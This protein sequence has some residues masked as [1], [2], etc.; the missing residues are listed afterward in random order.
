MKSIDEIREEYIRSYG[1]AIRGG[2][3]KAGY[4]QDELAE[5]IDVTRGTV[6][7]Y[8][9]GVLDVPGSS[10]GLISEVCRFPFERYVNRIGQEMMFDKIEEIIRSVYSIKGCGADC[11]IDGEELLTMRESQR[12]RM[13]SLMNSSNRQDILC[14]VRA[15][16]ALEDYCEIAPDDNRAAEVLK[17][18]RKK[19]AK[20]IQ[21][22]SELFHA[23]IE[24]GELKY[25][26]KC[27]DK[28]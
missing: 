23:S 15:I 16:S 21:E 4:T 19:A 7:R 24:Y 5:M 22:D 3:R 6:S 20:R 26:T 2:R 11:E 25:I 12:S 28:C 14:L 17:E 10:L 18:F 27:K 1:E 9:N 8:E 13:V